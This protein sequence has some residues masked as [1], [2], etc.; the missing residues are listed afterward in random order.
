MPTLFCS[1]S[2]FHVKRFQ[3][4]LLLLCAGFAAVAGAQS[5]CVSGSGT[6]A[7]SFTSNGV[8]TPLSTY[9]PSWTKV[10]GTADAY[11]TATSSIAIA[12]SNYAYYAF[13]PSSADVSQITVAASATNAFYGRE[14]CVRISA[15]GGYCVGFG[16]VING[17]YSGCYVEKGGQYLGNAGCGLLS[18]TANPL[19]CDH[20]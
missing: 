1:L 10:G 19:P 5:N 9:S 7:D 2:R 4:A 15:S 8:I 11:T 16:S 17:N 12:G 13:A 14:A 20:S 3:F 18:A 6:C